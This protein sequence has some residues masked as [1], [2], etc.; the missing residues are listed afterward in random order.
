MEPELKRAVTS[1]TDIGTEHRAS[2]VKLY[3]K[4]ALRKHRPGLDMQDTKFLLFL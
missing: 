4:C 1:C 2:L 3:S